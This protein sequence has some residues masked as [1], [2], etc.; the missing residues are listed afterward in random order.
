MIKKPTYEE[1]EQRCR[2]FEEEAVKHKQ[3]EEALRYFQQAVDSSSDAIGMSTPD[4]KHYYQNVA[5]TNL[6]GLYTEEVDG[7]EGPPSTVYMDER[8]GREVFGTI[9][10][11]DA[12]NGEVEMLDKKGNK[13]DVLLRAYSIKDEEGK[14]AVLVHQR[15]FV[16]NSRFRLQRRN[17]WGLTR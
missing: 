6:F 15:A 16:G 10:Q 1:L 5:F 12:W 14:V 13:L 3:I 17:L 4:G 8:I 11:G 7:E 2:E 9:M